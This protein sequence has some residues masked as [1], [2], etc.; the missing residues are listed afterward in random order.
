MKRIRWDRSGQEGIA[1]V[2]AI[3]IALIVSIMAAVVLNMTFRRF[4]LSAARTDHAIGM[5]AAEAGFQYA[6]ARMDRSQAFRTLVMNKSPAGSWYVITCHPVTNLD[7]GLVAYLT[8]RTGGT[9]VDRE[10]RAL[11]MG[12]RHVVL[13]I[14]YDRPQGNGGTPFPSTS[15][16]PR[17]YT[18]RSTSTFAGGQ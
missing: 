8:N 13:L 16:T 3:A 14:S 17:P 6:F 4:E 1:M 15:A 5:V 9:A 18:I 11:H 10:I 2:T 12:T 7:P